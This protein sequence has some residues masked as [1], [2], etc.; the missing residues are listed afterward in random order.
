MAKKAPVY[1]WVECINVQCSDPMCGNYCASPKTGSHL[2]TLEDYPDQD[3]RRPPLLPCSDRGCPHKTRAPKWPH[4][5]G[6]HA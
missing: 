2:I 3:P 1:W 4:Q 5:R 6:N